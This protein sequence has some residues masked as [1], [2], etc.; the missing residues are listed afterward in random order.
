MLQYVH[1]VAAGT[2]RKLTPQ[3]LRDFRQTGRPPRCRTLSKPETAPKLQNLPSFGPS[4]CGPL[5]NFT[6]SGRA[7]LA[8]LRQKLR[9]TTAGVAKL[10][11]KVW[12]FAR[13]CLD[14]LGI[15]GN[16][17]ESM[18]HG[19]F[20]VH[21][22]PQGQPRRRSWAVGKKRTPRAGCRSSAR[23]ATAQRQAWDWEQKAQK[24]RKNAP[25]R[26]RQAL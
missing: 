9:C 21:C 23:A 11:L 3:N 19:V 17:P 20:R 25:N 15:L 13:L 18:T 5:L 26:C 1:K 6:L 10:V 7:M 2:S 4:F 22:E 8:T 14:F 24:R 16:Q 12:G